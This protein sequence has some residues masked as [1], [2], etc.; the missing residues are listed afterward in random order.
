MNLYLLRHAK[1][2]DHGPRYPD[3]SQR[4]LT[5]DGEKEMRRVAK[6]MHEL[7]LKF[8]LI[9]SSPFVRAKRTA[10]I[11]AEVFKYGDPRFSENLACGGNPR[12][13][14]DELT[15]DHR[16]CENI[17]LV[18]H[19][20]DLS[21]MVSLLTTGGGG[22]RLSFK[23]AGLCKLKMEKLRADRCASLEWLMTPGNLEA[24]S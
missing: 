8:D 17:L 3:D 16:A 19:E 14:I 20:P 21:R 18:G 22:L 23:K 2:E 15:R 7:E 24:F 6:G 10:E 12:K 11:V 1:A 4:P 9:L 5:S 13:L